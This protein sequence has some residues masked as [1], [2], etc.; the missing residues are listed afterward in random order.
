MAR[1]EEKQGL[2]IK[3]PYDSNTFKGWV[4]AL[5]ITGFFMY[6]ISIARI[7]LTPPH[8]VETNDSIKSNIVFLSE[9]S[10]GDGDGTGQNKGNLQV[11][12]KS[13][14][15]EQI[16]DKLADAVAPKK[17]AVNR[18]AK[19]QPTDNNFSAKK[20][21]AS[22]DVKDIK[23]NENAPTKKATADE[24]TS[25]KG[26]SVTD[27]GSTT[28][29]GSPQG[30][31]N[32][33]GRGTKDNGGTGAGTG[34]GDIEWGGG[35]ST[36]VISK[37]LPRVPTGLNTSTIVKLRFTI[38]KDG[39]VTYTVPLIRGVPMAEKAVEEAFKKWKFKPPKTETSLTGVI[40]FRFDVN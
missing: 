19:S 12:G 31:V 29:K 40:T 16:K 9:I 24:N 2:T 20:I 8:I 4:T 6:L 25:K 17:D 18:I 5:A 23:K 35:G 33:T 11:E 10:F 21:T 39:D 1:Y 15:G 27:A 32:G 28:A 30:D 3:L 26:T 14:K 13:R 22:K 38:N 7:E 34:I 37:P 36:T